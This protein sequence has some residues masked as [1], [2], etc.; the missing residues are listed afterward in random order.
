MSS[1]RN[2]RLVS[3]RCV[4]HY[5]AD[6]LTAHLDR[7]VD[8][9]ALPPDARILLDLRESESVKDRSVGTLREM[10]DYF[11]ARAPRFG[12]RAALVVEGALRYGL[13]RMAA[14]WVEVHGVDAQVFRD[15]GEARRWLLGERPPP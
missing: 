3:I 4:G 15:E 5:G 13:M 6:E 14:A 8:D 10:A 2:G 7:H 12:N 11:V 9:P 1:E